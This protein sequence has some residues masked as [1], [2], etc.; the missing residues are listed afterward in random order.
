MPILFRNVSYDY[1]PHPFE[2]HPALNHVDLE[3]SEG[4]FVAVS[5]KA[6]SGKSTLLQHFNGILRPAEGAVQVLDFHIRS[7]EKNHDL[8][9]LRQR[10]GLVFQFPEQQ[11]FAETVEQDLCYGPRNFGYSD[12][13]AKQAA[14][15]AMEMMGL[16]LSLLQRSPFQLS[17]GQ[18]RK[19]AIASVLAMDPEVLV[20]DEP[21]AT[22]DPQSREEFLALLHKLSKELKKTIIVV[23]HRLEEILPYT[24]RLILMQQGTVAF[25]GTSFELYE[26][27]SL[28][29]R[30]GM[31]VPKPFRI[32]QA[33]EQRSEQ[34]LVSQE[35]AAHAAPFSVEWLAAQISSFGEKLQQTRSK[36]RDPIC[37]TNLS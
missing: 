23:T 31:A 30:I 36:G 16:P 29:T 22:L 35:Y 3:I 19:V 5:G 32:L 1:S 8:K 9:R 12:T 28:L 24:D 20:L 37:S 6:G 33:L 7:G 14:R 4:Q 15:R 18:M 27:A 17:G 11:L 10:V 26:Q 13:E 2:R 25:Q 21:T 34:L